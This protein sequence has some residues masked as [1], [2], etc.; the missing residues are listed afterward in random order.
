MNFSPLIS[1]VSNSGSNLQ[2]SSGFQWKKR[3]KM[4]KFNI[5]ATRINFS[6]AHLKVFLQIR[7]THRVVQQEYCSS[8]PQH[9]RRALTWMHNLLS[10][11]PSPPHPYQQSETNNR[12][13]ARSA[14]LS[15]LCWPTCSRTLPPSVSPGAGDVWLHVGY[16]FVCNKLAIRGECQQGNLNFCPWLLLLFTLGGL[17]LAKHGRNKKLVFLLFS[18]LY[19]AP[20]F[21]L[22]F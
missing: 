6:S 1:F 17:I 14:N 7:P 15:S 2:S 10:L 4:F 3:L 20:T 22:S 21:A 12:R 13:S 18:F 8:L 11:A 19:T 9:P 5:L 16:H